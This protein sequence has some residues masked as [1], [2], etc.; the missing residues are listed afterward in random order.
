MSHIGDD[1]C[2]NGGSCDTVYGDYN[3]N[4]M[5]INYLYDATAAYLIETV[6]CQPCDEQDTNAYCQA[7]QAS[8]DNVSEL[9]RRRLSQVRF[10]RDIV[11]LMGHRESMASAF[12]ME[13]EVFVHLFGRGRLEGVVGPSIRAVRAR[14]PRP[15]EFD[16][17][18]RVLLQES[19]NLSRPRP[20]PRRR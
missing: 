9:D 18:G 2:A 6:K 10:E 19:Q 7:Q 1:E 15:A 12:N 17:R 8:A 14:A 13:P 4:T 11:A 16:A 3:A 20:E 5:R